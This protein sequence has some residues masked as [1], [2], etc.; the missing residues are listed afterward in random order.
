[1]PQLTCCSLLF[2]LVC[3]CVLVSPSRGVESPQFTVVHAESEFEV[4][5]YRESSWMSAPSREFSFDRATKQGFHRLFQY[6]QGA[7][8]NSSRIP[9]TVPVITSIVPNAGPFHSS[10]YFV[11]L[12]LPDKFH[13]FPPVPLP[14]LDLKV[15]KWASRCIAVRTLSGFARDGNVIKE[16]EAL[17]VSL[18]RS[19]WAGSTY[20]EGNHAYSVAQYNSPFKFIGRVNEVWVDIDE[21]KA[22]GC[23][24]SSVQVY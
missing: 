15:D 2:L 1:M 13:A 18:R 10:A 6:I 17:A 7:N 21:S 4:R 16:A 14:E 12:Y 11:R 19:P 3:I 8:L 9:M 22:P 20:S 23:K 24:P 5:L